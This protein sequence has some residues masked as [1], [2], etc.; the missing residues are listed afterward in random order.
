MKTVEEYVMQYGEGFRWTITNA[1]SWLDDREPLWG[2]D[3]PINRDEFIAGLMS[4]AAP[5]ERE[6]K[7]KLGFSR[8]GLGNV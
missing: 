1:L 4:K 5:R 7:A 3:E 8:I 6:I 2:L